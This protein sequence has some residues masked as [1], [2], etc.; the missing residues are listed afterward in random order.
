MSAESKKKGD[1]EATAAVTALADGG[2]A[3]PTP[4]DALGHAVKTSGYSEELS[5][6]DLDDY[7]EGFH[8]GYAR[9]LHKEVL[10]LKTPNETPA[11]AGE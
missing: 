1:E 10:D 6:S 3:D 2:N 4:G 5:E 11:A 8:E 9:A 7:L